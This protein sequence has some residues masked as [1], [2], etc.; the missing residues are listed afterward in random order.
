M[1]APRKAVAKPQDHK[2]KA[3]AR[4]VENAFEFE[5]DGLVYDLPSVED[6]LSK[7]DGRVFR[8]ALMKPDE[9]GEL[10]MAFQALESSEPGEETLD[11]LYSK[12]APE[13][14][15]IVMSWFQH[16]QGATAGE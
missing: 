4:K 16:A 7:I 8:D 13:M 14:L 5:H 12:P 10:R 15:E 11:A 3:A 9:G 1:T 2:S 6:S